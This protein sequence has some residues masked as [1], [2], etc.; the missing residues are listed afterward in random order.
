ME[1][2]GH[3]SRIYLQNLM[4]A[5]GVRVG[6]LMLEKIPILVGVLK[7]QFPPKLEYVKREKN[8]MIV[9]IWPI[10]WRGSGYSSLPL[11]YLS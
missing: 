9:I 8:E 7:S 5:H 10:R 4:V 11:E 1:R 6:I 3:P 2:G